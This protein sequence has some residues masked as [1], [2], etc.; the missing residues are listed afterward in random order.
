MTALGLFLGIEP[1]RP[2]FF[3]LAGETIGFA[4]FLTVRMLALLVILVSAARSNLQF[5]WLPRAVPAAVTGADP[6]LTLRGFACLM[7]LI[8]HGTLVAFVP[9]DIHTIARTFN[10][11]R[12]LTASP[13]V[14]VWIFF[15]LSGYLM[16]KGFFGGRY[17]IDR[18][19]I[20]RFYGNRILRIAPIYWSAIL[21][22]AVVQARG[23]FQPDNLPGFVSSLLFFQSTNLPFVVI[24][25]LWSV[26]TEMGFYLAAPYLFVGLCWLTERFRPLNILIVLVAAGVLFRIAMLQLEG[27]L[28]QQIWSVSIFTPTISNLDLFC[29]GM[30]ANWLLEKRSARPWDRSL[31]IIGFMA[32]FF[33]GALIHSE[34]FAD[35]LL[36]TL[37]ELGP[38][39]TALTVTAM[40]IGLE[41]TK[42]HGRL[43]RGTQWFGI[44]TYAVYV[45]HEPVFIA[46]KQ[47]VPVDLSKV[48]SIELTAIAIAT[49]IVVAAIAY[50]LIERPF[51]LMRQKH[52][53]RKVRA[54]QYRATSLAML[55]CLCVCC[56]ADL[57]WG[58]FRSGL[59]SSA[60]QHSA[61]V[62]V[63]LC[64]G[65]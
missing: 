22:V 6:L 30:L 19:G 24:G 37:M 56:G 36:R 64:R 42:P 17:S 29:G 53:L 27:Y 25:A 51:D 35:H 9:S 62:D 41:T 8:G 65:S 23:V 18:K 57:G 12:L 38:C 15:V 39:I 60:E 54:N 4:L 10:P 16:G 34:I 33:G 46:I 5:N 2:L 14:G 48:Q 1:L 44:L 63:P 11:Y 7:V 31:I 3:E 43:I 58:Y 20:F 47:R 26:Q 59:I 52:G 50:W 49:T 61:D 40:I 13:W 45:V 55:M 21:I 28:G 32:L